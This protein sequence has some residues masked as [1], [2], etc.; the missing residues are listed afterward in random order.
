MYTENGQ[1]IMLQQTIAT[2]ENISGVNFNFSL[3]TRERNLF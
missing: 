3:S 2:E 1:D